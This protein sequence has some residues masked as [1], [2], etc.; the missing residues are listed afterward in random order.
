[1]KRLLFSV[2]TIFLL[3]GL[4]YADDFS[5]SFSNDPVGC[6]TCTTQFDASGIITTTGLITDVN[7]GAANINV[8]TGLSGTFDGSSI[9]LFDPQGNPVEGGTTYLYPGNGSN[10]PI[11]T[12]ELTFNYPLNFVTSTGQEWVLFRQ[13]GP[14][15]PGTDYIL[16]EYMNGSSSPTWV[17]AVDLTISV[18]EPET[19]GM[20]LTATVLLLLTLHF[21]KRVIRT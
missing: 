17:G 2:L 9:S 16:G 14:N 13:D 5:F 1:M 8:V 10:G 6:A 15:P 3:G 18:P 11:G 4:S 19:V 12:E 21:K 20:T 7:Y